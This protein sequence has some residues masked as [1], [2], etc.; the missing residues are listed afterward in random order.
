VSPLVYYTNGENRSVED[1]R[2]FI[3]PIIHRKLPENRPDTL[4]V[5]NI[6]DDMSTS[7]LSKKL[8]HH[9]AWEC[10]IHSLTRASRDARWKKY[11]TVT[12]PG[13]ANSVLNE[14]INKLQRQSLTNAFE[15]DKS[16]LGLTPLHNGGDSA[17]LEQVSPND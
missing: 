17:I 5:M 9:F 4:R 11:A 1:D 16:F 13:M 2:N 3:I 14:T 7:D 6:P 12:F 10:K 15:Y 8:E